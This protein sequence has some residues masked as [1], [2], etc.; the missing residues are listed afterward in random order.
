MIITG[1]KAHCLRTTN[2]IRIKTLKAATAISAVFLF[3][4]SAAQAEM[5]KFTAELTGAAQVAPTDSA[6]MVRI[7]VILDTEAKMVSWVVAGYE[8][9]GK[10][11]GEM[12]ASHIH[13]PATATENAP[14]I[15]ETTNGIEG[16]APITDEQIADLESGPTNLLERRLLA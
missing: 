9:E 14:P 13:G 10:L 5:M 4:G 2:M 7:D 12:T 3:V 11:S 6:A 1:R 16:S 8:G 15:I